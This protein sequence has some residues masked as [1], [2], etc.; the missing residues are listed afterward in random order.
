MAKMITPVTYPDWNWNSVVHRFCY[1]ISTLT[2]CR[3]LSILSG[4]HCH[5]RRHHRHYCCCYYRKGFDYVLFIV[6]CCYLINCKL[7]AADTSLKSSAQIVEKK[8]NRFDGETAHLLAAA[9]EE[10][11]DDEEIDEYQLLI[12]NKSAKGMY[13]GAPCDESCNSNLLHVHCDETTKLC[14]C[15]RNYP[16]KLGLTK[17]CAMPKKLG[18]QCW[19]H[20]TCTYNDANSLCVQVKH[21]ALCSCLPGYHSVTYTK[22]SKRVFCTQDLS[23]LTSDLPTLLGVSTGIAVLAGLICMVL[24]LFSKTKYPRHRNYGDAN[25]PPPIMYSTDTVHSARPSSRSSLRSSNSIGSYTNRRPS[26]APQSGSKGILVST[27]RSGAARSAAILLISCHIS[28]LNKTNG[29]DDNMTKHLQKQL[30]QQKQLLH[31]ELPTVNSKGL[32][33]KLGLNGNESHDDDYN[34]LD[35]GCWEL[36]AVPTPASD[37]PKVAVHEDHL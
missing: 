33:R 35:N 18:E 13:I 6:L 9:D 31:L 14:G 25:M 17:G 15:E 1:V 30:K 10:E 2:R 32:M 37:V 11:Y 22:P 5:R 28:A 23:V 36:G 34:S 3:K 29:S 21:N 7:I 12:S 8:V 24:H 4:R 27:S 26:S 20:Q 19:W 16:V